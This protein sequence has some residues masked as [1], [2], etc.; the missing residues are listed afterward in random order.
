MLKKKTKKFLVRILLFLLSTF[1]LLPY[2]QH[3]AIGETQFCISDPIL[4]IFAE[5]EDQD[6][7]SDSLYQINELVLNPYF[8][9]TNNKLVFFKNLSPLIYQ[10]FFE[11]HKTI[12]LRC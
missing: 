3:H 2:W 9:P 5:I 11:K 6:L 10:S 7:A 4:E 12:V 8:Q 1:L